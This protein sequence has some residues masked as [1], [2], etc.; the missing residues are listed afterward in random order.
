MSDRHTILGQ[1]ASL[2]RT[3]G[4]SGSQGF[5]SFQILNQA[6]LFSHTLGSQ[7]QAN[8]DSSQ[9]SFGYVGD[10]DTDQEDDSVEPLVA[11][12]QSNDE[13]SDTE[14]NG[15]SGDEMDKVGNLTSNRSLASV[16]SRSQTSD[17]THHRVVTDADDNC[18]CSTWQTQAISVSN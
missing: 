10:D 15:Y 2:I 12:S 14:E 4:R 3:D 8:C 16:Q 18:A 5:N 1:C 9:Q 6:V 17:T 7:S 11:K 13:E